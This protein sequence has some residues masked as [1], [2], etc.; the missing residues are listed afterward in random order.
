[1]N[2]NNK[3][4]Y[5]VLI[6]IFLL[7]ITN[8]CEQYNAKEQNYIPTNRQ[9]EDTI[10][11]NYI[12]PRI[13]A[14]RGYWNTPSSAE[15]SVRSLIKA[16]SIGCYGSEVDV[17]IT[18]DGTVVIHHDS[19]IDSMEIQNSLYKTIENKSIRNGELIPTLESYTEVAKKLNIKLIC[20][21]KP[22]A[23]KMRLYACRGVLKIK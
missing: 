12:L 17:W 9:S 5:D 21:I 1:M 2:D 22:H 15:N 3:T 13:I 10:P 14:H 18:K 19:N 11:S 4:I 23:D 20:E 6:F 7:L 16:D 8:S